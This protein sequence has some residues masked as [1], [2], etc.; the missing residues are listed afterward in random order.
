MRLKQYLQ[1]HIERVT[2][3]TSRTKTTP[4]IEAQAAADDLARVQKTNEGYFAVYWVT[5]I[6]VFIATLTVAIFLRAEMGGLGSV[7]GVGGVLQ[8]G[9]V[10]RLSSEWK[11]KARIDIVAALSRRLTPEQLQPVLQAIMAGIGK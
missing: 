3:G 1:L 4:E 10:L 9:L 11:E 2:Q 5:L 8:A 6:V 7:L